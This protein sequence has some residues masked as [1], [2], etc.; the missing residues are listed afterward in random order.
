MFEKAFNLAQEAHFGQLRHDGSPYFWHPLRV[1]LCFDDSD[2][3]LRT[4]AILHDVIEDCA[5]TRESLKQ[6]GFPDFVIEAVVAISRDKGENYQDYIERVCQNKL[7]REVKVFDIIDNIVTCKS[8]LLKRYIKALEKIALF[9]SPE[10]R[11]SILGFCQGV[12]AKPVQRH[13]KDPENR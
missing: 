2:I 8:K 6:S 4:V 3:D 10:D 12:R 1:A 5:F 7:A 9:F 13:K 11:E